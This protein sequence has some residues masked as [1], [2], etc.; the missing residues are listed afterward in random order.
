MPFS[1][2]WI[3]SNIEV[4]PGQKDQHVQL[5]TA[6]AMMGKVFVRQSGTEEGE[7]AY[8]FDYTEDSRTAWNATASG[9]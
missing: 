8:F 6:V 5:E 1:T 3:K 7:L 2:N 9:K 4:K